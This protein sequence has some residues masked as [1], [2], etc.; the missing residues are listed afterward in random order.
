[1]SKD[2]ILKSSIK[3]EMGLDL[4]NATLVTTFIWFYNIGIMYNQLMVIAIIIHPVSQ[5]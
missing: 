5:F 1:M 3:M 4:S 2:V